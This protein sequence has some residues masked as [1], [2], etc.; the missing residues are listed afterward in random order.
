M[1]FMRFFALLLTELRPRQW[2][3]NLLVFGALLFSLRIAT[4][5]MV[6]RAA[7]GFLLFCLVSGC[8]Y[9]FN[10]FAD[11]E[12]DRQHPEKR[13]RPMAAGTLNPYLALL[14]AAF[15]L[16]GTLGMACWLDAAFGLLLTV[17]FLLTLAY[18]FYWKH[19]VIVDVMVIATG[20]V[21]RAVG[22]AIIIGVV[23]TPWFLICAMWLALFLAISKRRHEMRLAE[24]NISSA[25]RVL[26]AYTP[27]LLNQL[28]SIV[29][30]ATIMSYAL[31]TFTSGRTLQLMWTI[32]FVMYGI[33]RY[34]Y[35][36]YVE[37]RGGKPEEV[38][39]G[40]KHILA[41]V[42]GFGCAVAFILFYFE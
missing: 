4:Q 21:M 23:F 2:T 42:L 10:D 32:P 30:T 3:K 37:E 27:E 33:F 38:L 26:A 17:Y 9:I 41:T 13:H 29:T 8:V 40:D 34:L 39:L 22:G 16:T 31:F 18:S 25:R 15:L 1:E 35:L 11:R 28:I 6:C 5:A 20:F 14:F 7:V 24:H 36:V 12:A 19:I